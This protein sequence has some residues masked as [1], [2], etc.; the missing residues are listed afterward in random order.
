[1]AFPGDLSSYV[2]GWL[3]SLVCLATS[4]TTVFLVDSQATFLYDGVFWSTR[5]VHSGIMVFLGHLKSYGQG[6]RHFQVNSLATYVLGLWHSAFLVQLPSYGCHFLVN[7]SNVHWWR[8]FQVNFVAT[9]RDGW[10]FL[11][12]SKVH[13]RMLTFPDQLPRYF[14]EK[15]ACSY[16]Q[17]AM[18]KD[19]A[20]LRSAEY[21]YRY[22]YTPVQFG[23]CHFCIHRLSPRMMPNVSLILILSW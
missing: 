19:D 6:R 20:V 17:K 11:V 7:S 2:Q 9:F 16:Q 18:F 12:R 10:C 15:V 4:G 5:I 21:W 22:W 8:H 14:R 1:M 13:S 23:P 3:C